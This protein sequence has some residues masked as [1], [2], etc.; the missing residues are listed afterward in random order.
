MLN[1]ILQMKG[2]LMEAKSP[3]T[4]GIFVGRAK[5]LKRIAGADSER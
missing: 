1:F 3:F 2:C 5:G 4:T